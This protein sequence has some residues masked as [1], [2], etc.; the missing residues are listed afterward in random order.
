[1]ILLADSG[2]TKTKWVFVHQEKVVKECIT[3]GIN[4]FFRNTFDY[5]KNV[6]ISDMKK[7]TIQFISDVSREASRKTLK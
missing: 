4:P 7:E 2:S 3:S 6:I 1:M 5:N